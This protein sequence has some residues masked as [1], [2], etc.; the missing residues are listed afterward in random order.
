MQSKPERGIGLMAAA[1]TI[2]LTAQVVVAAGAEG[3]VNINKASAEQLA[4]LPRIGPA[5]AARIIEFR[6][7]NGPFEATTDL[8][9][10]RGIGDKTYELI[11]PYVTI[12]GDTSLGEKVRVERGGDTS[13][14]R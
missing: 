13:D 7:Q 5:V 14:R 10:V 3:V 8:L 1:L 6:E 4:F 9:L 11:E 12:T 2:L